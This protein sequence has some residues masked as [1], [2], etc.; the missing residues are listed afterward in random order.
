MFGDI[1]LRA[2]DGLIFVAFSMFGD[3]LRVSFFL[4]LFGFNN[5]NKHNYA[6]RKP[7]RKSNGTRNEIVTLL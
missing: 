3:I 4:V 6:A 2:C 5:H 1:I 7:A